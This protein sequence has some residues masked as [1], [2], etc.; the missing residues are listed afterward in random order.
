MKGALGGG[1]PRYA[2]RQIL[3]LWFLRYAHHPRNTEIV[4]TSESPGRRPRQK[5]NFHENVQRHQY[6][7]SECGVYC[8]N[9]ITHL[10]NNQ[11]F[12]NYNSVKRPDDSIFQF[13]DVYFNEND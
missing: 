5:N 8:I 12:E 4:W 1:I 7:E 9:F 2:F 6:K 11:T 10:L 3:L 13:R